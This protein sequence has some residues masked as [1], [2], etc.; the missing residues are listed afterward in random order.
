MYVFACMYVCVCACACVN[1]CICMYV[2]MCV[3][4]CACVN[5]CACMYV[6]V[7]VYLVCVQSPCA[8]VCTVSRCGVDVCVRVCTYV[9]AF[10]VRFG[11]HGERE[12]YTLVS[13]FGVPSNL[14]I[15][16]V[17]GQS[18]GVCRGNVDVAPHE[19]PK[20]GLEVTQYPPQD[21]LHVFDMRRVTKVRLLN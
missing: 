3:C 8:C 10:K 7:C 2:C 19:A 13:E 12:G 9:G 21:V 14:D 11:V 16:V 6:H 17:R 18:L 5:V 4:A 1:V 15:V 20:V